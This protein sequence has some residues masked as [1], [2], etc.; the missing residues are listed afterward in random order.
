M[1]EEF[2]LDAA[3]YPARIAGRK[4]IIGDVSR[5]DAAGSND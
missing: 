1:N 3:N 5:D 4:Y 2:R